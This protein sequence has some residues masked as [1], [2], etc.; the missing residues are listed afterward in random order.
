MAR[1]AGIVGETSDGTQSLLQRDLES[2]RL[3]MD[4]GTDEV[5][6]KM[7]ALEGKVS[8][9]EANM[10]EIKGKVDTVEANMQEIKE[11]VDTIKGKMDTME[12]MMSKMM[13]MLANE[14]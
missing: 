5:K 12:E 9:I 13:S 14:E 7:D 2:I 6:N 1:S 11:N 3:K 8:V 10:Q 4:A